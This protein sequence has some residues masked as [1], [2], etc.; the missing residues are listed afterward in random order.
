MEKYISK[1]ATE[2]NSNSYVSNLTCNPWTVQKF[3]VEEATKEKLILQ[4]HTRILLLV[5][6]TPLKE[7]RWHNIKAILHSLLQLLHSIV[8]FNK[9]IEISWFPSRDGSKGIMLTFRQFI[10]PLCFSN[11]RTFKESVTFCQNRM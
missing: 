11:L 6:D 2:S 1:P 3:P 4:R 7:D 5:A 8:Y 9:L 10:F